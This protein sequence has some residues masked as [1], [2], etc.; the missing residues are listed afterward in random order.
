M[1]RE[2]YCVKIDEALDAYFGKTERVATPYGNGHINDT[3][4]VVA[5]GRYILQRMNHEIFTE[6]EKMMENILGVTEHIRKK[7]A[8]LDK[9]T[10]RCT[11][12][13]LPTKEGANFFRDSI[14]SYWRLYEFVEGTVTKETVE[15]AED[16]Y[17]CAVA[18]GKFQRQ[19]A[20]YDAEKLYPTIKDFHNTPDRYAKLMAAIER[21]AAGRAESV[22]PEIEFAKARKGFCSVL[23]REREAGRLPLRVTHNDT[24]LN[25]ILFDETTGEPICVIDLD[26][27]MSGYSV[28]DFGDSI[29]FGANTAAE[30]ETDLSKVSLD[31]NLFEL[32]A[33]G[34]IE[35]CG[36]RLTD[37]ELELLPEG[38]IMM[39]LECGM[40]FLTDYLDGDVYFRIHREGHNLDRCRN[41]FALV[42][43]MEKKLPLMREIIKKLK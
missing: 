24:K 27:V 42:A 40:R 13:V 26:T 4:L 21:N 36:G 37:A 5:D 35:G 43:D 39:T 34:F 8:E 15:N 25:N 31:M 14:G 30:D 20:D 2:E 38:A 3:F 23:E 18:F 1:T 6:P 32:Y 16:F 7:N 28:T 19:L 17:T 41:Q 12:T 10:E 11:L 33:K 29:R 22:L 9:D